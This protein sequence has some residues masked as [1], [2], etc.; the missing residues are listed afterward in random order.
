MSNAS[1]ILYSTYLPTSGQD[2]QFLET[3]ARLNFDISQNIDD[4]LAV[5]IGTDTNVSSKSTKRR[6][7][8]M[9]TFLDFHS[10]KTILPNM[11]PTFHHNNQSSESQIDH[12]YFSTPENSKISVRYKNQLCLKQNSSNL[13]SHDILIGE[14]LLPSFS[15]GVSEEDFSATYTTFVVKEPNWNI[16][17]IED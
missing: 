3:L 12:I 10:L 14:L 16:S 5:I 9:Q 7:S 11:E 17:G 15:K 6:Y 13:S 8:A 1:A 2:E 4:T